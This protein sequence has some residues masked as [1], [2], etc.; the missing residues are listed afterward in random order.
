MVVGGRFVASRL[1]R[2]NL[3]CRVVVGVSNSSSRRSSSSSSSN[4][5]DL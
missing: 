4:C 1:A 5:C 3:R 2:T